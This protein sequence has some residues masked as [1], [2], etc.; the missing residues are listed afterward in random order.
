MD[1]STPQ[2]RLFTPKRLLILG[3]ALLVI[4]QSV[5]YGIKTSQRDGHRSAFLRW[6]PQLLEMQQGVDVQEK[7]LYPNPPIM[8]LILLPIVQL[9]D[10]FGWSP[11][12]GAMLWFYLKVAMTIGLFWMVFR[13]VEDPAKPFPFWAKAL[14]VGLSLRPLM[15]DLSHG[16]VNLFIFF[17]IVLGLYA[18]HHRQQVVA[19]LSIALAIACKTTPAL[20]IP[21]LVWK[22][23][24]NA[25][26]GCAVGLLLFFWP[27]FVPA[28]Y[29]GW[30]HQQQMTE[31]W[32]NNMVK[33]FLVDGFVT[34]EHNNQSL[35][36]VAHRLLTHSP[37]FS[38]YN[39]QHQYVPL[40]YHNVVSLSQDTVRWLIKGVM[41]LFVLLIAWTCRP[42]LKDPKPEDN[43][44]QAA[45]FSLV[46]LGML[47]F[48]ERT[49]KHHCVVFVLPFAVYCYFLATNW[50]N[51]G[52]RRFLIGSMVAM[53][54]ILSTT[55]TSLM[56]YELGKLAQVYGAYMWV[57]VLMMGILTILLRRRDKK[58][59]QSN[60]LDLPKPSLR[61][62]G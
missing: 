61:Q 55:S 7:Y 40:E 31:S 3:L 58:E 57:F 12:V 33:P 26:I 37:S 50:T 62:A 53:L 47:L 34:T 59:A 27:G 36:G 45:E 52:L 17:L 30:D 42:T 11:I 38:D 35:P 2:T 54:L 8:G 24:T 6:R 23:A 51:Q 39:E 9:P 44:Y 60:T 56:G 46:L 14:T 29:F 20:F 1:A 10:L 25:L 41:L 18:L 13:M 32:V 16:N 15:G 21:Y 22:R 28:S 43:P 4:G 5:Q 49:W 48:S 19:G